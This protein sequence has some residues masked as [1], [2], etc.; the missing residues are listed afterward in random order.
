MVLLSDDL[1]IDI[2]SL[3]CFD[4]WLFKPLDIFDPRDIRVKDESS[5]WQSAAFALRFC[6][7]GEGDFTGRSGF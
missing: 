1:D 7:I 5:D 4:I 6:W 3:T 2:A